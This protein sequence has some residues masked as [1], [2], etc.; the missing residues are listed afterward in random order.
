MK[1]TLILLVLFPAC[2][3]TLAQ[4]SEVNNP[5]RQESRA[6]VEAVK[7]QPVPVAD[8]K[9]LP[10]AEVSA[11]ENDD[12][13]AEVVPHV[14]AESDENRSVAA[15][16]FKETLEKAITPA[17]QAEG[18]RNSLEKAVEL[19]LKNVLVTVPRLP[20]TA[21]GEER[22]HWKPALVQSFIFLG[23]QHG[24]RMTEGKTRAE[25]GGPFFRDWKESVQNLEGWDDGGKV[26][27]NYIAH[28]LQGSLTGRIFVNNSD[29]AKRQ[30]IGA[31][32][33]YWAS[34]LRALAWSAVWS[35]Q[36]EIGPISEASLGNVGQRRDSFGRS[37]LTWL[38]IVITPTVGTGLLV[39]EDAM[40]KYVLKNW[41]E[42]KTN[43]ML[44]IKILRSFLTPTTSM[45][46]I[47]RG[48][49]PWRRD[50][51]FNKIEGGQRID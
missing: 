49:A 31:S 17:A 3:S 29:H 22:F 10:K 11:A 23:L 37:K 27:T 5:P 47:I 26:F 24:F 16:S 35:T 33:D 25:L 20:Q 9:D 2:L 28:P 32:K 40:D 36:F 44:L 39:A 21:N 45:A 15:V 43:S 12:A 7:N 38:D 42:T 4:Q 6:A 30:E 13:A 18:E 46:N 8:E 50:T 1:I 51:R 19:D 48:K 41:L 14:A 34:R